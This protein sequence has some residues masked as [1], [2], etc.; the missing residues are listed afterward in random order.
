MLRI[1]LFHP[2]DSHLLYFLLLFSCGTGLSGEAVRDCFSVIVGVDLSRNM[3]KKA[4]AR[5][6]YSHVVHADVIE[7]VRRWSQERRGDHPPSSIAKEEEKIKE[8]TE[9]EKILPPQILELEETLTPPVPSFD[10][11]LA[12]DMLVYLGDLKDLFHLVA[13]LL[14][15]GGLFIASTEAPT[16]TAE[17]RKEGEEAL[18][19]GEEEV[20]EKEEEEE[21]GRGGEE[22]RIEGR[23]S[24]LPEG[25]EVNTTGRFQHS[26]SYIHNLAKEVGLRV[27]SQDLH[28]LRKNGGV[29]VTG[30]VHVLQKP[31]Q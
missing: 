30:F 15:P 19:R 18:Q 24:V 13:T 6:C 3:L 23:G 25:V 8:E 29:D 4:A 17:M 11:V 5:G 26:R 27:M 1:N 2:V 14:R 20:K 28:V 10:V 31:E 22:N 7:L 9:E 16:D 21:K 12:V